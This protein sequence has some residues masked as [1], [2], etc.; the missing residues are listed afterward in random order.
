MDSAKITKGIVGVV[1][2]AAFACFVFLLTNTFADTAASTNV[3]PN[4]I[5]IATTTVSRG[6]G[7]PERLEI[8]SISVNAHVQHVGL[9]ANKAMGI[10]T[11]FTDVGWYMYG[12]V[13]GEV[14][15]AVMDG[16]VDNALGLPGVFKK[17]QNVKI[18]DEIYVTDEKGNK[19]TFKVTKVA[20]YNYKE[21]PAEE[22]FHESSRTLLQLI[23]CGGKWLR[24]DKTYDT[25]VVVTAEYVE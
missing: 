22:I 14:G 15:S 20:S 25:R 18:G 3:V 13:P 2:A 5:P 11:N 6:Y 4:Y 17:L 8:P 7:K 21:T 23:T 12:S 1:T 16:H 19:I 10:P 24:A 9:T